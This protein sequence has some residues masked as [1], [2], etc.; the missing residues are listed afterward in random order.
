MRTTVD[1]PDELFRKAKTTAA[2][3]GVSLRAL[4]I[5]SLSEALSEP[6]RYGHGELP[7]API[8]GEGPRVTLTNPQIEEL[9]VMEEVKKYGRKGLA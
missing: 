6:E 2:M 5:E 8:G 7:V 4:I 9:L 3:R 1:L